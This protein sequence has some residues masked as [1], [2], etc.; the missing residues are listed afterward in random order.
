[1]KSIYLCVCVLLL[2]LQEKSQEKKC[3]YEFGKASYYSNYLEGHKTAS[4]EIFHQNK[5]T[6]AHPS[7]SFGTWVKVLNLTNKKSVIVRI[8]DRG[9]FVKARIIDLSKSAAKQLGNINKGVFSV[10]VQ[11][12]KKDT[13]YITIKK[14]SNLTLRISNY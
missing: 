14:N 7:L 6:A 13:S 2:N 9:P 5:F 1:M 10:F 3:F 8:N 12:Y 4:G 11:V